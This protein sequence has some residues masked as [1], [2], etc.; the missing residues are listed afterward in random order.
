MPRGTTAAENRALAAAIQE[1]ASVAQSETVAPLLRFLSAFPRSA[2]RPSLLA[3]VGTV[4]RSNGFYAAALNAWH[5]A[6]VDEEQTV[7]LLDRMLGH[8]APSLCQGLAD[9]RHRQ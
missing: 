7:H 4:Y 2:W 6:W 8:Q 5:L 9:H 1:Y 3:N